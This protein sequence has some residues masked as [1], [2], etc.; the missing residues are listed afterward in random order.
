MKKI[1]CNKLV[2]DSTYPGIEFDDDG[3]SNYYYDFQD[4]VLPNWKC[5]DKGKNE[6][7]KNIELI[8]KEGKNKEFDCILGMS[9]GADSSYMLHKMVT[10]YDL[11]PLVFHVD[12]G[13]NSEIAVNNINVLIE[14]LGLD[15]YTEVIEWNE[16]KKFQL[17]MFKS[18][19]PHLDIPQ[20][21]AFIGVLYKFAHKY[22]IKYILN[23]GNISTESIQRP[24]KYIYW[25]GDL[26]QV[27][28]ITKKFSDNNF[29]SFPFVSAYYYK[30]F[31]PIFKSI[32]ILR[33]LNYIQYDKSKAMAELQNLYGWKPYPQKH[34]ESRFTRFFEGYWLPQRFNFD[35][36]TVDLSSLIA[37]SQL[38]RED[39]LEKLKEL[40]YSKDLMEDDFKYVA[41]KLDISEDELKSY[42][43]MPQK[44]FYDYKNSK[45]IFDMGEYILSK[46]NIRR[47]GSF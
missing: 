12:G 24:K 40:P 43:N 3:I 47:G 28:D 11:R 15:L 44:Y 1:V 5:D 20:D 29:H 39:A 8:K 33:P 45:L 18:G 14:K 30:L 46:F 38:S 4:N 41:T 13:W 16:M 37:T 25:G 42:E 23:G 35:M 27:K 19:V 2:L 21:M 34:F 9:G 32:K 10:D 36:R 22:N 17:A 7:E 26:R 6:L 31:L